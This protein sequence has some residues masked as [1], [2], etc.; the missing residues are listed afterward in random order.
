[1][2]VEDK[3]EG[4]AHNKHLQLMRDYFIVSLYTALDFENIWIKN[5]ICQM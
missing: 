1:M 4:Q 2:T 3:D 5:A